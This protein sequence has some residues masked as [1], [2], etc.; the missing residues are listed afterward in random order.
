MVKS[1]TRFYFVR[2]VQALGNVQKRFQGV[3]DNDITPHGEIQLNNVA[4]FFTDKEI[5]IIYSSP[6]IRAKKTAFAIEKVSNATVE[7]SEQIKEIFV[8]PWENMP[9]EQ[10]KAGWPEDFENWG[11]APWKF[12]VEGAETMVAVFQRCS[13]FIQRVKEENKGQN[14]AIVAHGGVMKSLICAT[15]NK[16]ITQLTDIGW[17][18]NGGVSLVEVNEFGEPVLQYVN[19]YE[20]ID[21]ETVLIPSYAKIKREEREKP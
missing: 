16:P 3:T 11:T 21:K 20:H 10:I 19:D 17:I 13:H 18:A 2:H 6:L 9:L 5:D 15:L 12:N 14:I 8:G 7:V 4:D 1:V